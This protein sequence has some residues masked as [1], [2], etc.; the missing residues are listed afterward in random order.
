MLERGLSIKLV[1]RS[2]LEVRDRSWKGVTID[3]Q[4]IEDSESQQCERHPWNLRERS[5]VGV[6]GNEGR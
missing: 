5:A 6:V 1:A 4:A 2:V 3:R